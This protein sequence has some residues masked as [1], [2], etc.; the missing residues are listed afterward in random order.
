MVCIPKN[1]AVD[2]RE[3]NLAGI[4]AIIKKIIFRPLSF[5]S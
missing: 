2:F 3:I 1:I 5:S 4:E